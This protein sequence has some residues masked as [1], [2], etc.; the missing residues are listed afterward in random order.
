MHG[1][2]G[3]GCRCILLY[4][5]VLTY[6]SKICECRHGLP[7]TACKAKSPTIFDILHQ[8][9]TTYEESED[10][11]T[12]VGEDLMHRECQ[13]KTPSPPSWAKYTITML[14]ALAKF[15]P[16]VLISCAKGERTV[17]W[18]ADMFVDDKD[19]CTSSTQSETSGE[20]NNMF[21]DFRLAAKAWERI[22]CASGGLL[23]L[24]KWYWWV[25]AWR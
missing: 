11:Y 6:L 19:M 22:M 23:D 17:H 5:R 25:V 15:N 16:G 21:T 9:Q 7:K 3:D 1:G 10:Y 8:V 20:I 2:H 12:S 18:L 14:W 4:D 13:G 24:H